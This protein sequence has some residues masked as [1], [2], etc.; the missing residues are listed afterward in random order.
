MVVEQPCKQEAVHRGNLVIL[1]EFLRSFAFEYD[2][3]NGPITPD[4]IDDA[5][6]FAN[7]DAKHRI[8][9]EVYYHWK[10]DWHDDEDLMVAI[11]QKRWNK[12]LKESKIALDSVSDRVKQTHAILQRFE[13]WSVKAIAQKNLL[14]TSTPVENTTSTLHPACWSS[15]LNIPGACHFAKILP[16]LPISSGASDDEGVTNDIGQISATGDAKQ[17]D[18]DENINLHAHDGPCFLALPP[19]TLTSREYLRLARMMSLLPDDHSRLQAANSPLTWVQKEGVGLGDFR[20]TAPDLVALWI[21]AQRNTCALRHLWQIFSVSEQVQRHSLTIRGSSGSGKRLVQVQSED[22]DEEEKLP[23]QFVAKMIGN[24]RKTRARIVNE[25]SYV[26][27]LVTWAVINEVMCTFHHLRDMIKTRLILRKRRLSGLYHNSRKRRRVEQ[28]DQQEDYLRNACQS[29]VLRW[30]A[31][32]H[33]DTL[34]VLFFSNPASLARSDALI[35]KMCDAGVPLEIHSKVADDSKSFVQIDRNIGR[36]KYRTFERFYEVVNNLLEAMSSSI[37]PELLAPNT[38]RDI[39]AD[40][41][42]MY[43]TF[44]KERNPAGSAGLLLDL[45]ALSPE[46]SLAELL[47]SLPAPWADRCRTCS[48]SIRNSDAV[49]C[50][51]CGESYHSGCCEK[52]D[53]DRCQ[54]FDLIRKLWTLSVPRSLLPGPDFRGKE[55]WTTLNITV[56]REA[57]NDG[58]LPRLGLSLINTEECVEF[59]DLLVSGNADVSKL[60][61]KRHINPIRVEQ[62]GCIVTEVHSEAKGCGKAAGIQRGDVIVGLEFRSF[63]DPSVEA[64]YLPR[65]LHSFAK[66]SNSERMDMF[67]RPATEMRILIERPDFDIL[68]QSNEF[69][70]VVRQV[71]DPIVRAMAVAKSKT[72]LCGKCVAR[73]AGERGSLPV[74]L[75]DAILARSLLRC[76]GADYYAV[77]LHDEEIRHEQYNCI[78]PDSMHVSLRRL[79][80][81]MTSIIARQSNAQRCDDAMLG[82]PFNRPPWSK[83]D[84]GDRLDWAPEELE[85]KPLELLCRGVKLLVSTSAELLDEG[86]LEKTMLLARNFVVLFSSWYPSSPADNLVESPGPPEGAFCARVPWIRD[87]CDFCQVRSG[88]IAPEAGDDIAF[89]VCGSQACRA[90]LVAELSHSDTGDRRSTKFKN[91]KFPIASTDLALIEYEESSSFIGATV[92]ILPGDAVLR[93]VQERLGFNIEHSGRVVE[94]IVASYLPGF[95]WKNH[96][97]GDHTGTG[98]EVEGEG[99]FHLLPVLSQHQLQFLLQRCKLR[100]APSEQ[101]STDIEWLSLDVLELNGVLRLSPAELRRRLVETKSINAALDRALA[102][103]AMVGI[104]NSLVNR[105]NVEVNQVGDSAGSHFLGPTSPSCAFL[106]GSEAHKSSECQA[107]ESISR[108]IQQS[109]EVTI[110]EKQKQSS[111]LSEITEMLIPLL[112]RCGRDEDF[113][114]HISDSLDY[115]SECVRILPENQIATQNDESSVPACIVK[116][117]DLYFRS[118]E[119]KRRMRD[120]LRGQQPKEPHPTSITFRSLSTADS[121]LFTVVLDREDSSKANVEGKYTGPGWGLELLV[122]PR[123]DSNVRVGRVHPISPAAVAGLATHD[124]VMSI[125]GYDVRGRHD[126][127]AWAMINFIE[128]QKRAL[129]VTELSNLFKNP[130]NSPITPVVLV[131]C[132]PTMHQQ[133]LGGAQRNRASTDTEKVPRLIE[134]I[135]RNSSFHLLSPHNLAQQT[136]R[137]SLLK[138]ASPH[139]SAITVAKNALTAE[140]AFGNL[141]TSRDSQSAAPQAHARF[142]NP[143][144]HCT[145]GRSEGTLGEGKKNFSHPDSLPLA[146]RVDARGVSTLPAQPRQRDCTESGSITFNTYRSGSSNAT[147]IPMKHGAGSGRYQMNHSTRASSLD[148]VNVANRSITHPTNNIYTAE[149]ST[150]Q[151]GRAIV[152]ATEALT[153]CAALLL[154][155]YETVRDSYQLSRVLSFRDIYRPTIPNI[156]FTN[157]EASVRELSN[158]QHNSPAAKS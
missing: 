126:F 30:F 104:D 34:A 46:Q 79:D 86:L 151:S 31:R 123:V 127:V 35:G 54:A 87:C 64:K 2:V 145:S 37:T 70:Q 74:V 29:Y 105:D 24:S 56:V 90:Q 17:P 20:F 27:E 44:L 91:S 157:P 59:Y 122:W 21:R 129:T 136:L 96:N 143:S 147:S 108:C 85:F 14:P 25:S 88:E 116:Y 50:S 132:R 52:R 45:S 109:A 125:N 83:S 58:M 11:Q 49:V 117:S 98:S 62:K 148:L 67:R 28:T 103:A 47:R 15:L 149:S 135:S 75:R 72:W 55:K 69:L 41:D 89:R 138:A 16:N 33:I 113:A 128:G 36:G 115:S 38:M 60:D 66:L 118:H 26:D 119:E 42:D 23:R 8:L 22:Q 158:N 130:R 154:R 48:E 134:P 137:S 3:E 84:K 94:F 6:E 153:A 155:I 19:N 133:P 146:F 106:Q 80:G 78:I 76:L 57:G 131:V 7:Q 150:L 107:V 124:V 111:F 120:A 12:I 10:R 101:G 114:W 99:T 93:S 53:V 5:L 13:V 32:R 110:C 140:P 9:E 18:D 61:E 4:D 71:N 95:T 139:A 73:Q 82:V 142:S 152:A 77:P 1:S 141:S 112:G 68:Q 156:I 63:L 39:I 40:F 121:A 81:M 43:E 144:L 97:S 102:M 100:K 92:L 51:C 65:Q